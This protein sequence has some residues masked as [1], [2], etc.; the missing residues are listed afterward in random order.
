M[1]GDQRGGGV[2]SREH[3]E[4]TLATATARSKQVNYVAWGVAVFVMIY[5]TPI[6]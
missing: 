3:L 2:N 1:G 5:G 4:D 6:A